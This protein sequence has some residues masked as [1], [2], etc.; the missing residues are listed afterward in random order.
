M[1]VERAGEEAGNTGSGASA[2][3]E[4]VEH[5]RKASQWLKKMARPRNREGNRTR[6]YKSCHKES[7]RTRWL[8]EPGRP[9]TE[10]ANYSNPINGFRRKSR[11][12]VPVCFVRLMSDQERRVRN[13]NRS[14][15][16]VMDL[17]ARILNE[18]V[19]NGIIKKMTASHAG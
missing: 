9:V 16:S 6:S 14:R 17:G 4:G 13:E 11:E 1:E 10:G 3:W 8:S 5:G 12:C 15:F 2:H 18:I 7:V 19:A